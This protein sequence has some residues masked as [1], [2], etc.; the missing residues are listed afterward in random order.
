MITIELGPS[1]PH[2]EQDDYENALADAAEQ[3]LAEIQERNK[4]C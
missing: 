1:K 3:T 4:S 2:C